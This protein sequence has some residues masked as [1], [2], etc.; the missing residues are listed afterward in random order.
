MHLNAWLYMHVG[1]GRAELLEEAR[2]K[3]GST[4]LE[5]AAQEF[6][7]EAWR[8]WTSTYPRSYTEDSEVCSTL[9]SQEEETEALTLQGLLS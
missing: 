6:P 5:I 9:L 3:I 1:A 4:P 2:K 7:L 8:V